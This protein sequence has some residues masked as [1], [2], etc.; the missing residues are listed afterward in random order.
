MTAAY[1]PI[2]GSSCAKATSAAEMQYRIDRPIRGRSGARI[3][4]LDAGARAIVERIS[5]EPWG[6]ARFFSL[7]EPVGDVGGRGSQ[8]VFLRDADG[9]TSSLVSE[10]DAAD[11]VIMVATTHADAAAATIIGAACTVRAIMTAGLVI[12]EG[13]DATISALRPHARVLLVGGDERDVVDLLTAL[14]A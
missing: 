7:A 1:K 4:A 10:L 8:A 3:I 2:L 11:V 14:R 5:L 13:V 9:R 12:G 6:H